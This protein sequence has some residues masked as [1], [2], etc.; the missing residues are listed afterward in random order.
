[1][2]LLILSIVFFS[3]NNILW[4]QNLMKIETY[5][6][7]ML[8][9]LFTSLISL[10]L[11]FLFSKNQIIE[12]GFYPMIILGSLFGFL[13]LVSMLYIIK[14]VNLKWLG[15]YNLI[16]IAFSGAYL[17]FLE[18]VNVLKYIYGISLVCIGFFI[19]I[20]SNNNKSAFYD[21]KSHLMAILM[22]FSFQMAA[23][24]HWKNLESN[25]SPF[26]VVFNQE[27]VVF[28]C[29]T[30]IVLCNNNFKYAIVNF[31]KNGIQIFIMAVIILSALICSFFGLKITNPLLSSVA[32]LSGPITTIFLGFLI[33]KEKVGYLDIIAIIFIIMG[34][35]I[36]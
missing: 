12:F 7:I 23:F 3:L 1:M 10:F 32:S 8:R 19:Y 28:I 14:N 31:K 33:F 9:S 6:L 15:F 5:S 34:I 30:F 13:G 21:F 11:I 22:T 2:F 25:I 26:I 24:L 18:E 27:L 20:K 17:Y 36:I 16:G 29:A 4:K 35:L